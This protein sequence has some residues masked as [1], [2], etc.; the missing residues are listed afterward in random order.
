MINSQM[1]T[2][3]ENVCR[4]LFTHFS[5]NVEYE[6]LVK[7]VLIFFMD[8]RFFIKVVKDLPEVT[9]NPVEEFHFFFNFFY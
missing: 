1:K 2:R 5:K 3:L 4:N 7:L 8:W 6:I 9:T